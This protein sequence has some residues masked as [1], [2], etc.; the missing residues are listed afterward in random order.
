MTLVILYP[1]FVRYMYKLD[2]CAFSLALKPG[3]T[4]W[5]QS[6]VDHRNAS[7]VRRFISLVLF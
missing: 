3:V 7:L 5:Y 4:E 6:R 2:S 1:F